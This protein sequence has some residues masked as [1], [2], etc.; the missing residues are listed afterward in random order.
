MDHYLEINNLQHAQILITVANKEAQEF[1][2]EYLL[3]QGE[4][5]VQDFFF[6]C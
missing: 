3:A 4:K 6:F 1:I 2:K 5:T